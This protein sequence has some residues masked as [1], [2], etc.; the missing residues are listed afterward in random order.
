MT[1]KLSVTSNDHEDGDEACTKTWLKCALPDPTL[2]T[3]EEITASVRL[4]L[5]NTDKH[6]VKVKDFHSDQLEVLSISD[7]SKSSDLET[8]HET[9]QLH[10]LTQRAETVLKEILSK[11]LVQLTTLGLPG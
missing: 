3:A 1:F 7:G 6:P 11:L 9:Y 8:N 10:Q 2:L 4:E 5:Q